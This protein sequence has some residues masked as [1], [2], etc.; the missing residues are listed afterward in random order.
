MSS[1]TRTL[2]LAYIFKSRGIPVVY[3]HGQLDFFEK[4]ENAKVWL[5]GKALIMCATSAFGMGIDKPDV[6]FVIHLTLPRS[7]EDYFQEAGRAGRDGNPSSCIVWFRFRDRNQLMNTMSAEKSEEEVEYLRNSIN[8]VVTY[9]MSTAC[10]RELIMA[11]FGDKS[12]VVCGETCDNCTKPAPPLKEYTKEA[13][14]IC[15]CVEEMKRV[16]P[17]ISTRQ[18]ALTFKGSKSKREVESKGFH[19]IEHYSAGQ[20]SFKNDVDATTFIHHLLV[21]NVLIENDRVVNGRC[22]TPFITVGSKLKE[23]KNGDVQIWIN[24]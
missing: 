21:R 11:H 2:E 9:C 18:L 19:M 15:K 24:L 1:S 13:I 22:T 4:S 20:S 16:Q 14:M 7:T 3:Y 6:R 8:D 10:R 12:N 17:L 23:L 5:K